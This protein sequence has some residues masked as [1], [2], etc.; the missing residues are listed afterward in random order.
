MINEIRSNINGFPDYYIT[1]C[2]KVWSFK[3]NKFLSLKKH[4]YGYLY[5]D[6]YNENERSR[7]YV[8]RL[9]AQA[10]IPNPEN[11]LQI[12]HIDGN[13]KNNCVKN[14]EWNTPSENLQHAYN[15]GLRK[16][17]KIKCVET[18]EIFN[19]IKEA[20]KFVNKSRRSI[21]YC[22]SGDSKTCGGFHWCYYEGDDV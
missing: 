19:S 2:G 12:N 8:H 10:Y 15:I 7:F 20:A 18:G 14:L 17:K 16:T 1:S 13:K 3:S 22:L 5:I 6:L 21:N 11:K 4:K 9:V